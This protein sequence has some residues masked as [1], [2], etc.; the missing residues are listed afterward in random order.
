MGCIGIYR[1]ADPV[2]DHTA[3]PP[4]LYT[5]TIYCVLPPTIYYILCILYLVC[6]LCGKILYIVIHYVIEGLTL[7]RP[8][9]RACMVGC[10]NAPV[11]R[12][13]GV[14]LRFLG[15]GGMF[16]CLRPFSRKKGGFSCFL[17]GWCLRGQRIAR[18]DTLPISYLHTG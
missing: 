6:V 3:P 2:P 10:Y 17:L 13:T 4:P 9:S 16:P 18:G 12:S 7:P 15:W 5:N 14:S 11:A 1:P 8:R